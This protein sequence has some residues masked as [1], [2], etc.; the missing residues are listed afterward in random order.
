MNRRDF[1]S[2]LAASTVLGGAVPALARPA[3]A[4]GSAAGISGSDLRF[5]FVLNRGGWDP[6]RVFAPEFSN[7]NVS[8]ESGA[9]TATVGDVRYVDH[10]DRPAVRAFMEG[11]AGRSL[12][13]NG[14]Q[15]RSINHEVCTYLTLTGSTSGLAP[16]WP[17]ILA[18]ARAEDFPL[19]HLVLGGASYPG[20]FGVAVAR[21]GQVGQ[22]EGLLTGHA[23]DTSDQPTT[24]LSG[25]V[26]G[27]V[28]RYTLRRT[29]ARAASARGS[30]QQ[31]LARAYDDSVRKA[32][33]L[34]DYAYVMDFAGGSG[35]AQ[36][37]DVAVDALA[38]GLSRCITM[39]YPADS[40]GLAWDT[41]A[42]NDRGQ[43][44]LFEGLF[45]GL[46]RLM[47]LLDGTTD[48]AGAP[49]SQSTVVVVLSEMGRSPAKNGT[50]G[51]DHWPYTSAMLLGPGLDTGR[52]VGGFDDYYAGALIDPETG[53][54]RDD[55]RLLSVE[56]LGATLLKL[57][58]V[59]PAEWVS[60]ATSL[61]GLLA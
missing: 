57:G 21:T 10:P 61:P 33:D 12:I 6:T 58:D 56:A 31:R 4:T 50:D 24:G 40:A 52:V 7:P 46:A 1:L 59:D 18:T 17:A 13:L 22:L 28:D 19:P 27:L 29:A 26:E 25:P 34:E 16:D 38:I 49:L 48:A 41:H 53:E 60:G 55:G 35:L 45:E 15:V 54:L 47:T 9:E 2:R 23:L 51:K 44:T 14:M 43:S 30:R 32:F 36:Q 42:R 11:N 37:A 8:M 3:R 5:L 39:G 20:E